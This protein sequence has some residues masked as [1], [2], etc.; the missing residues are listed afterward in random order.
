MIDFASEGPLGDVTYDET[1]THATIGVGGG[2]VNILDRIRLANEEARNCFVMDTDEQAIRGSVVEEKFLL[3]KRRLRGL[4][5]GGDMRLASQLWPEQEVEIAEMLEGLETAFVV[6]A[7][8]GGTGS[9]L[10]PHLVSWLKD[11]GVG[12]IVFA[13]TPFE[14]EGQ[15]KRK[16][17][18]ESL[19]RLKQSADGIYV[20]S[21]QRCLHLPEADKDI[22][23][24]MHEINGDLAQAVETLRRLSREKG[25]SQV[26]W[27]DLSAM[28]LASDM[29]SGTLETAWTGSGEAAG[30][31]RLERVV[32]DAIQGVMM[33]DGTGW[34]YAQRAFAGLIGGPDLSMSEYQAVIRALKSDLPDGFPIGS[35][36]LVDPSMGDRL[37]LTLFLSGP[38]G[39]PDNCLLDLPASTQGGGIIENQSDLAHEE[40]NFEP[41][42]IDGIESGADA[43]VDEAGAE[44]DDSQFGDCHPEEAVAEEELFGIESMG[45]GESQIYF[46][47]QEELPLERQNHRGRFEKTA[48]TIY[49]GEDLDQPTFQRLGISIRL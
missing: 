23:W 6:T 10:A 13:V 45:A 1:G 35:G 12:V 33:E 41:T 17:A 40:E 30:P 49:D 27:N 29:E 48:P 38:C 26:T 11:Q 19:R 4:G 25:L 31:D 37:R 44:L 7:L 3:G 32:E 36:A 34:K 20:F 8:G 42:R 28:G 21:N 22:R 15:E 24:C 9:G 18:A 47:E 2:G 5:C 46:S 39:D 16:R 14:F 43:V